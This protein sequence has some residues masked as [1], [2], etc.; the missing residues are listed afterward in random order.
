MRDRL[1]EF[2]PLLLAA[3]ILIAFQLSRGPGLTLPDFLPQAPTA[4]PSPT[5]AAAPTQTPR[6]A[7][8]SVNPSCSPALP[9]FVGGLATLKATLGSMMGDP[10]ECE[11]AVDAGGNTQQRT[12]TG[13]AYYRKELNAACFTTGWD[14]WGLLGRGLVHWTGDAVDPPAG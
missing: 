11:H 8:S 10:L 7:I 12:T 5:I 6:R 2:L 13:L 1:M 3:V 4:V 14:H 9:S